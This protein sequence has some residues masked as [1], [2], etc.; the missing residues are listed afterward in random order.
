MGRAGLLTAGIAM[1]VALVGVDGQLND[2]GL[3]YEGNPDA[4]APYLLRFVAIALAAILI[5]VGARRLAEGAGQ[6]PR[7]VSEPSNL[8]LAMA[9]GV[10][11]AITA[12]TVLLVVVSPET[13][14]ELVLEDH[15]VE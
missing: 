4:S 5:M 9:T 2:R 10:G 6:V 1:T 12:G 14:N 15:P 3:F 13:L 7:L 8:S 11:V